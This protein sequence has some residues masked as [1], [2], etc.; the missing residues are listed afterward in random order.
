[1]Y[2]KKY[3]MKFCAGITLFYPTKNEL[4]SIL[5]YIQVFEKIYVY[6]NTDNIEK[7]K[8]NSTYFTNNNKFEYFSYC[9]NFG[10]SVALNKMCKNSII[11]SF[12]YICL[13]DQDSI[14]NNTSLSNM[15]SYISSTKD[16]SV[17]IYTPEIIYSSQ[18]E[19][20]VNKNS[21]KIEG[22]KVK[23]AITSGSFLNLDIFKLTEGF[24]KNYFID[25]LD[26]DYCVQLRDL[27]YKIIQI[28]NTFL[29]QQL[30]HENR[31]M[32]FKIS[33]HS[34][35]RHYYVFRNRLY[36]YLDKRFSFLNILIIIVLSIGHLFTIII[37]SDSISKFKIL[38]QSIVDY[39]S[40]KMGKYGA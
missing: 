6:D 28:K 8:T 36:F 20:V 33:E 30:G 21:L 40:G 32:G 2:N 34:A 12:D 5:N 25:R 9:E 19:M 24:D 31:F 26:Y 3:N 17:G 16:S 39:S 11:N 10:L 35:L 37:E 14:I 4:E 18:S 13:F 29:F 23:W 22:L 15:I 38:R 27:G 1:M 7:Q